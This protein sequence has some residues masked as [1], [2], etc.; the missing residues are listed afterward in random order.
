MNSRS[1]YASYRPARVVEAKNERGEYPVACKSNSVREN[2]TF[3]GFVVEDGLVS[4]ERSTWHKWIPPVAMVT[5]AAAPASMSPTV[6]RWSGNG[7]GYEGCQPGLESKARRKDGRHPRNSSFDWG[8]NNMP[9]L[10]TQSKLGLNITHCTK[11]RNYLNREGGE[12]TKVG[13]VRG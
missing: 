1:S 9:Y 11:T 6:A 4:L 2:R 8:D 13:E 5:R 3:S 12:G 7:D 10:S